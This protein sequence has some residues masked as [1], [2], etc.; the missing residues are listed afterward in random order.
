MDGDEQNATGVFNETRQVSH[1]SVVVVNQRYVS[2][3]QQTR[4]LSQ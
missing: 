1:C 3:R 2:R 4:C